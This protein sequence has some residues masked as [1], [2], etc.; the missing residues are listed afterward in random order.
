MVEASTQRGKLGGNNHFAA[1][2]FQ[3]PVLIMFVHLCC[4]SRLP[5]TSR[6]TLNRKRS[7]KVS[8]RH[9]VF[10]PTDGDV[11]P[12]E[13]G[14][15]TDAA[16][17]VAQVLA[18]TRLRESRGRLGDLLK[19]MREGGG[20]DDTPAPAAWLPRGDP[21]AAWHSLV[22]SEPHLSPLGKG[23]NMGFHT[24]CS[25][26]S[27]PTQVTTLGPFSSVE[28]KGDG[29]PLVHTSTKCSDCNERQKRTTCAELLPELLMI[30]YKRFDNK[31]HKQNHPSSSPL[32][33]AG[34]EGGE[35][36]AVHYRLVGVVLAKSGKT[37]T[38]AVYAAQLCTGDPGKERW[39]LVC[40]GRAAGMTGTPYSR[41]SQK[42]CLGLYA[43]KRDASPESAQLEVDL[44]VI[45]P[46]TQPP[47][48][49]P[50]VLLPPPV[51]FANPQ[52]AVEFPLFSQGKAKVLIYD[53]TRLGGPVP[54]QF[55][56]LEAISCLSCSPE[57]TS[58][59]LVSFEDALGWTDVGASHSSGHYALAVLA[60]GAGGKRPDTP[61]PS[62]AAGLL[63]RV[64]RGDCSDDEQWDE[65][66]RLKNCV[67]SEQRFTADCR[68]TVSVARASLVMLTRTTEKSVAYHEYNTEVGF[69]R[70]VLPPMTPSVLS[71]SPL[72]LVY[73]AANSTFLSLVA[74][75]ALAT[76][77]PQVQ[78][79][80]ALQLLMS[81]RP[82]TSAPQI[83]TSCFVKTGNNLA[84]KVCREE[85]VEL[86]KLYS[87]KSLRFATG[88]INADQPASS[89]K[90]LQLNHLKSAMHKAAVGLKDKHQQPPS[91]NTP[92]PVVN[93]QRGSTPV[94]QRII[95]ATEDQRRAIYCLIVKVATLTQEGRGM[96]GLANEA[97][98][99]EMCGLPHLATHNSRCAGRDMQDVLYRVVQNNLVQEVKAC[100]VGTI[101]IDGSTYGKLDIQV[102]F[103]CGLDRDSGKVKDWCLG[104]FDVKEATAQGIKDGMCAHLRELGL[105]LWAKQSVW[106]FA[107]D[108][109][110]T[111]I[112]TKTLLEAEF[113]HRLLLVHDLSHLHQNSVKVIRNV[114]AVKAHRKTTR[115]YFTYFNTSHKRLVALEKENKDALTFP[116]EHTIRWAAHTANVMKA[117]FVNLPASLKMMQKVSPPPPVFHEISTTA[118]YKTTALLRD[119]MDCCAVV[120]TRLQTA[121]LQLDEGQQLIDLQNATLAVLARGAGTYQ[122]QVG[123]L[124]NK[125]ETEEL[126]RLR[127]S[128]CHMISKDLKKRW[129][130]YPGRRYA[131]FFSTDL[132]T[133]LQTM[134]QMGSDIGMPVGDIVTAMERWSEV[135]VTRSPDVHVKDFVLQHLLSTNETT[136]LEFFLELAIA[137]SPTTVIVESA[138]SKIKARRGKHRRRIAT[139]RLCMELIIGAHL[140]NEKDPRVDV[141]NE[142]AVQY[143]TDKRRRFKPRQVSLTAASLSLHQ[144][145]TNYATVNLDAPEFNWDDYD[146]WTVLSMSA[147]SS[148]EQTRRNAGRKRVRIV[149]DGNSDSD[150]ASPVRT[151]QRSADMDE[152]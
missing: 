46:P 27:S 107:S 7:A 126:S 68:L 123:E 149:D 109:A 30:D 73:N 39:S 52:P 18:S 80:D 83:D 147:A 4:S 72:R 113:A 25:C 150:E 92:A 24:V 78:Q 140:P 74:I 5:L 137:I 66:I 138:H 43:R 61:T 12:T 84:C 22:E 136:P 40:E 75:P 82:S 11:R 55:V 63:G 143:L 124:D 62:S 102:L 8:G 15:V 94:A 47:Q 79:I 9:W 125:E 141:L 21:S 90:S 130:E 33:L 128:L 144:L 16:A 54:P 131:G 101:K 51:S 69:T 100:A 99:L 70:S 26:P 41:P 117:A 58:T 29:P 49:P 142:V 122:T 45:E 129:D 38:Q 57:V 28:V 121:S 111:M 104:C 34:V 10:S 118:Y 145:L 2:L 134:S 119:I 31:G 37:R 20:S 116:R 135:Y 120:S 76:T 95:T 106:A 32:T 88:D 36:T 50:P 56:L 97:R 3:M 146:S 53:S 59:K 65:V 96:G 42:L 86:Q 115:S 64:Q 14:Q 89:L 23:R 91:I 152:P 103:V 133:V 148:V 93:V 139:P 127:G 48:P 112:A 19:W 77:Q 60:A 71:T 110:T 17:C 81:R 98:D 85:L 105:F 151:R 6:Q 44:D 114:R 67:L 13:R 35:G 132:S 108:Q 1:T 87:G